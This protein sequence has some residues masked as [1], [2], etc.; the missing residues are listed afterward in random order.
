[1]T[2]GHSGQTSLDRVVGLQLASGAWHKVQLFWFLRQGSARNLA[3]L[4]PLTRPYVCVY[5]HLCMCV[6]THTCE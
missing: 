6:S 3:L 1:M 2:S 5:E 4:G